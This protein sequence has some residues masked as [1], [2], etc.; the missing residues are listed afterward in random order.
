MKERARARREALTAIDKFGES[1]RSGRDR[2]FLD[3]LRSD[4][5]AHSLE[6][7]W[8]TIQKHRRTPKDG[9]SIIN[10]ALVARMVATTYWRL[11]D[12]LRE[13]EE[14]CAKARANLGELR[15]YFAK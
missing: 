6:Q 4:H 8:S 11:P 3:R 1:A 10:N 7:I 13:Q 5:Y 12:Q 2:E 9:V 15:G 14:K